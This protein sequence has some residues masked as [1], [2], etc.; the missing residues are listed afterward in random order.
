M[1]DVLKTQGGKATW[2]M[3]DRCEGFLEAITHAEEIDESNRIGFF[4]RDTI[5]ENSL[6]REIL[7]LE[8]D[9]PT[10]DCP[11]YGGV[12]VGIVTSKGVGELTVLLDFNDL[13]SYEY[14]QRG[15]QLDYGRLY[16][17][18][19]EHYITSLSNVLNSPKALKERKMIKKEE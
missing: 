7:K 19:M 6:A 4:P 8:P 2:N 1:K 10:K 12:K 18:D 5:E 3:F 14:T 13:Y 15:V 11:H 9:Y 16:V 17:W